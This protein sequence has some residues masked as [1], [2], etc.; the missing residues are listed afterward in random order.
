M[1]FAIGGLV[2]IFMLL[3]L[4][5]AIGVV[6][7]EIASSRQKN[8][9]N[10]SLKAM[11]GMACVITS[12]VVFGYSLAAGNSFDILIT[13]Y[14]LVLPDISNQKTLL[15]LV[16][17]IPI[18]LM[19]SGMIAA[20]AGERIRYQHWMLTMT[21]MGGMLWPILTNFLWNGWAKNSHA[22]DLN[23]FG[24]I[25]EGR[26]GTI[27][28][29]GGWIALALLIVIGP[30]R[31]S[32]FPRFNEQGID[33][34]FRATRFQI[35]FRYPGM[36]ALSIFAV[37]IG[38]LAMMVSGNLHIALSNQNAAQFSVQTILIMVINS[39][40]AATV[41]IIAAL[42]VRQIFFSYVSS[43]QGLMGGMFGGVVAVSFG[44][45]HYTVQDVVLVSVVAGIL[46]AIGQGVFIRLMIDDASGLVAPAIMAG[47]WGM[48]ATALFVPPS[49]FVGGHDGPSQLL[50]Q[51]QAL[52]ALS[53]S[54]LGV[55]IIL[56]RLI[57]WATDMR[58][59]RE[60]E[61]LGINLLDAGVDV[62]TM[63]LIEQMIH[64][65]L[66]NDFSDPVQ[67]DP[68]SDVAVVAQIYNNVLERLHIET[69]RRQVAT[70][71]L[72]QIA[73][74]DSLTGL[75]NR[76]LLFDLIQRAMGRSHR[77][78]RNGAMLMLDIDSFKTINERYGHSV[79][80]NVLM[81]LSQRIADAI[82]ETDALA[83][84]GGDQFGILL[85]DLSSAETPKIV[86]AKIIDAVTRPIQVAGATE[87]LSMSIG[88]AVFGPGQIDSV[89]TIMR[90]AEMALGQ[91][92]ISGR[93]VVRYY[94]PL[95]EGVNDPG[96]FTGGH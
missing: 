41:S 43:L 96:F 85:E 40:L 81:Q 24:Y 18:L 83:R 69:V 55:S 86:A 84:I 62:P 57:D 76:R 66:K 12:F 38:L 45:A 44:V 1:S 54:A 37:G 88:I 74:Y 91:S 21:V 16:Y 3:S 70:L 51:L 28:A 13:E 2:I 80:D 64:Q 59:S 77:S 75:A 95:A 30:R 89:E 92:K 35:G 52:I 14:R 79:G 19:M 53:G 5:G 48:L 87:R 58:V 39:F 61:Q 93:G 15:T 34:H 65:Q 23:L 29:T 56:F 63:G 27:F 94:D 47:A 67:V 4:G 73:N 11:T 25:D 8:M 20:A 78:G 31:G 60:E 26:I 42:I 7:L 33:R 22:A 32:E 90:K 71:R 49:G 36:A 82:R 9:I 46:S 17:Q 6:G 10:V 72:A 68:E 50:F